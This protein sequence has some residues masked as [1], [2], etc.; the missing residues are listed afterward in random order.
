[1]LSPLVA[2]SW[3]NFWLG[4]AFLGGIFAIA[5]AVALA[6]VLP[7]LKPK[8]QSTPEDSWRTKTINDP[9]VPP[10]PTATE[11][12]TQ[13]W[14][15]R[16]LL[17]R[18][19]WDIAKYGTVEQIRPDYVD[20]NEQYYL[21]S[22]VR[23]W[24]RTKIG[25]HRR[26]AIQRRWGARQSRWRA[27]RLEM[28]RKEAYQRARAAFPHLWDLQRLHFERHWPDYGEQPEQIMGIPDVVVQF[29]SDGRSGEIHLW[30][31]ER[32]EHAEQTNEF[33]RDSL[34]EKEELMA[35]QQEEAER[36]AKQRVVHVDELPLPPS[37]SK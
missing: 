4:L 9:P 31:L 32:V 30:A 3:A 11:L 2:S 22:R 18:A 36:R 12:Q 1:M 29:N 27:R 14:T 7:R 34:R 25:I 17:S 26:P 21:R 23:E 5:S 24:E 20:L 19:G 16:Q 15:S 28:R 35:A 13:Y 6:R 37:Y 10:N 8:G 33:I